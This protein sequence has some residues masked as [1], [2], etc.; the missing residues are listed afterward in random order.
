MGLWGE[1]RGI[2]WGACG[3]R[4][5]DR[6]GPLNGHENIGQPQRIPM[7]KVFSGVIGRTFRSRHSVQQ[8]IAVPIVSRLQGMYA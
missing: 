7:G 2:V 6:V 8:L 3:H 1:V 5:A 4:S